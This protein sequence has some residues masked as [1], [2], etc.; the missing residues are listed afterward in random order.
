MRQIQQTVKQ[1]P[2]GRSW[3]CSVQAV[4]DGGAA[5]EASVGRSG[6]TESGDEDASSC[7]DELSLGA[8]KQAGVDSA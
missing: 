4:G 2:K 7:L 1:Q 3:S 6:A 5:D 8:R